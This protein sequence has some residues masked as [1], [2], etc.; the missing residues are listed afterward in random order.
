MKRRRGRAERRGEGAER[1]R[2]SDAKRGQQGGRAMRGGREAAKRGVGPAWRAAGPCSASFRAFRGCLGGTQQ[3]ASSS[4]PPPSPPLNLSLTYPLGPWKAI[5]ACSGFRQRWWGTSSLGRSTAASSLR[6]L[7][8]NLRVPGCSRFFGP[9]PKA[10]SRWYSGGQAPCLGSRPMTSSRP[11]KEHPNHFPA[12]TLSH[13]VSKSQFP[14][15]LL[16]MTFLV[17]AY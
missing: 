15:D 7:G 4:T 17:H 10:R 1:G 2:G 3:R 14:G 16:S 11:L 9:L 5:L 8:S 12:A 13:H 6:C